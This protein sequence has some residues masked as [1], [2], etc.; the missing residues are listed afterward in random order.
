MLFCLILRCC[1]KLSILDAVFSVIFILNV[2]FSF[3]KPQGS[4]TS[5]SL[6]N[7]DEISILDDEGNTLEEI[8]LK[9]VWQ[10]ATVVFVSKD[11]NN[12]NDGKTSS[13]AIK[14]IVT[15][16][17]KLNS[18]GI[19]ADYN[20]TETEENIRYSIIISKQNKNDM[21]SQKM[22]FYIQGR[23][24]THIFL[25]HTPHPQNSEGAVTK[26]CSLAVLFHVKHFTPLY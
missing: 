23:K 12:S 6:T 2:G 3:L 10:D 7:W 13:N 17:E 8:H 15:A 20:E 1:G 22:W 25:F 18:A 11:G 14:D 24:P 19:K 16:F 4:N 21:K 9:A 26:G 5:K